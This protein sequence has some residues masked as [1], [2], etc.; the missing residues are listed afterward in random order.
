MNGLHTGCDCPTSHSACDSGPAPWSPPQ[1]TQS[2]HARARTPRATHA[3]VQ[4]HS[5][6]RPRPHGTIKRHIGTIKR[7]IG[8]ETNYRAISC[9][10][11][12]SIRLLVDANICSFDMFLWTQLMPLVCMV[13]FAWCS[14]EVDCPNV[15]FDCAV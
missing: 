1:H 8:T 7:H 2:H 6:T 11:A 14:D 3:L 12:L 13:S 15:P 10:I 4:S 9:I 5:I